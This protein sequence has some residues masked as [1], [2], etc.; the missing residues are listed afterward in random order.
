[1]MKR[2]WRFQAMK[3]EGFIKL[4]W[5]VVLFLVALGW[6]WMKQTIGQPVEQTAEETHVEAERPW[7]WRIK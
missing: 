2:K 6:G 5:V 3:R 4:L 1:M 7:W